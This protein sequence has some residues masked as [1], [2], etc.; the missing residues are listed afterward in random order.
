VPPV[1]VRHALGAYDVH[2]RPGL[3]AEAGALVR[4]AIGERP[5][6]V[7]TDP[8]VAALFPRW[9]LG[10]LA[11]EPLLVPPGEAAK[12]RE[13]WARLTDQ[14][15]ERGLGRD[16][17]IL[18]VGGGSV[19]DLA[20]FVAA[21]Y[22][23][24]VPVV[25]VPTTLLAMLDASVGGKVAVDTP[26]GKNLVGAFHPPALV[27]ADP[28]TLVTLPER[29][30][31][32]GLAEALKH[33]LVADAAYLEWI[34]AHAREL[35]ARDPSVLERLIARSVEIKAAVVGADERESGQRAILNAGHTVAHA[36]EQ[37]SGFTVL[38]GEAVGLG[39]V[40][41]CRLAERLGVAGAGPAARVVEA[42]RALGL[43]VGLDRPLGA[44][45]LV[46]AMATDK[47]NRGGSLRFALVAEPGRPAR[48]GDDWTTPAA[49]DLVVEALKE[50]IG[51]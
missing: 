35:G 9:R 4:G 8:T 1:S 14:L 40:A 39:L 15:L 45:A 31:R 41:E 18:A 23:R 17:A 30:Y 6:A 7:I 21:T 51:A 22:L 34:V 20:G 29:E 33:G 27:L 24:G 44:E 12:T 16:G 36:I 13:E 28:A 50:A 48:H 10:D 3:L 42:L 32:A 19:G 25:Q 49:P 2:V 5:L 11:G 43:P 37:V 46:A 26:H 47:K 38:H